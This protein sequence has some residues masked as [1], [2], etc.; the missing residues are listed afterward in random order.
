MYWTCVGQRMGSTVVETLAGI[1]MLED[2][3]LTV[4]NETVEGVSNSK[5]VDD[6]RIAVFVSERE[7]ERTFRIRTHWASGWL[8]PLVDVR[9]APDEAFRPAGV[10]EGAEALGY[11][12][13]GGAH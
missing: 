12:A 9:T 5:V 7:G 1:D 11:E 2:V 6:D 13:D 10:L 4:R 8:E 3:R